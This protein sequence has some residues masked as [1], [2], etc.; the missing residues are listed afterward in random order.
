MKIRSAR[1]YEKK[2]NNRGMCV[3]LKHLE[4]GTY[5]CITLIRF[6]M[7]SFRC[8]CVCVRQG[9]QRT[10]SIVPSW[11]RSLRSQEDAA[12]CMPNVWRKE[13]VRA[14]MLDLSALFLMRNKFSFRILIVSKF[15]AFVMHN[16]NATFPPA[17]RLQMGKGT[18]FQFITDRNECKTCTFI[19]WSMPNVFRTWNILP[20]AWLM[21][22]RF[23]VL[24]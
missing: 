23:C 21:T 24:W 9:V 4:H 15:D 18:D 22:D 7:Q 13:V 6:S 11:M 20:I 2:P 16:E 14:D 1:R 19:W 8:M 3:H 12:K 10:Y 17:D 5:L